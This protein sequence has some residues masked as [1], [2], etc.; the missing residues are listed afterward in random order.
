V[1]DLLGVLVELMTEVL[2][3]VT[4]GAIETAF[5]LKEPC[6][7]C[8]GTG[9]L[10]EP[11]DNEKCPICEGRGKVRRSDGDRVAGENAQDG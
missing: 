1:S 7:A 8:G 4:G 3:H 11:F 2:V 6:R 9:R 5:I 10:P